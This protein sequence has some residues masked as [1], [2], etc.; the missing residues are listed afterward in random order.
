MESR[1]DLLEV[2][3]EDLSAFPKY[4]TRKFDMYHQMRK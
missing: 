3:Q 2:D 1:K 4:L